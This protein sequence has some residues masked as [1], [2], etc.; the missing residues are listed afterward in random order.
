MTRLIDSL[1]GAREAKPLEWDHGWATP[2]VK[3][4]RYANP[5]MGFN[6]GFTLP[7]H[8]YDCDRAE[9]MDWLRSQ[10]VNIFQCGGH[11][12]AEI[13]A[14]VDGVGSRDLANEW[15]PTFLPR[16]DAWIVKHLGKRAA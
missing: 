6:I 3:A 13:F 16:F 9:M 7:K 15:L 1:F 10:G 2:H 12:G 8:P 4:T 14:I 11:P 5:H